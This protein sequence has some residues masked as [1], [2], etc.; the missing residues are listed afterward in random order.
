MAET[1][2]NVSGIKNYKTLCDYLVVKSGCAFD[3]VHKQREL[4]HWFFGA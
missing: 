4:I 1:R 3:S 2:I